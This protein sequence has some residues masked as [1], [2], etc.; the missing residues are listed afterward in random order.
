MKIRNVMRV[1]A[2]LLS[3]V[4]A[5]SSTPP[6]PCATDVDCAA[7]MAERVCDAVQHQ[8]VAGAPRAS[9][10][11]SL[12]GTPSTVTLTPL[13]QPDKVRIPTGLAFNPAQPNQLWVVDQQDDTVITI[14]D[15]TDAAATLQRRHDP[16]ALHFMHKPTGIAFADDNTWATCGEN[17]GSDDG[18]P[19][20]TGPA[21][22]SADPTIFAKATAS[23][24]G[25]HIDMLHDTEWCMGITHE[26]DHVWWVF[27][28]GQQSLA[29]Y[30]FHAYHDPGGDDH[31][32]GEIAQYV[33]GQLARQEGVPSGLAFDSANAQLY[34]AD[35][36][37]GRIVKLDTT[38]GTIGDTLPTLEPSVPVAMDGATLVE[39]VPPGTL[40]APS[41]MVLSDGILYV[42]DHATARISAFDLNGQL[43]RYLDTGM[44]ADSLGALALGPDGKLY[45]AD[46]STSI[47]YRVN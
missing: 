13:Y 42:V 40:Q 17:D 9:L 3:G 47:V 37:H 38:T 4:A 29:R 25:S 35:T 12:D 43:V 21:V 10:I 1:I 23:G 36:G 34:V 44:A 6:T 24:L 15:V 8:C 39:L 19:G 45:V 33:I 22:F 31:S 32:D 26:R 14:G 18:E 46:M 7:N 5:C 11:G 28:G 41:G 30:D 16:D 27:D 2:L 20:F